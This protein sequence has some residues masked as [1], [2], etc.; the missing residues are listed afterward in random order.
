MTTI[1]PDGL[2]SASRATTRGQFALVGIAT[3]LTAII[4]NSL[5]YFVGRIVVSYDPDFVI[6]QNVLPTIIF[7]VVPAIIA[8]LLYGLLRRFTA[9]P[10]RTFTIV[11]AVVLVLSIIPDLTYMPTVEGASAGQTAILIVMHIV[12]A[13]TITGMLT[14]L[15]PRDSR[16]S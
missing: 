10:E 7:T 14:R 3:I 11:A 16:R 5:V 2:T 9:Q 8:V 13:V 1:S 15:A 6:F 4:A 12:A